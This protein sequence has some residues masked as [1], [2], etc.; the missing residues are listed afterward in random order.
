M[1]RFSQKRIG[2]TLGDPKGIGPEVVQKALALP[3][4]QNQATFS[5]YGDP[6]FFSYDL[7]GP[8]S[9]KECGKISGQA[10][11]QAVADALSKKIDA[12]VTAPIC[13]THFHK[14]G[15]PYPGHTEFLAAL[16]KTKEV[17]MMMAGPKLRVVL[18]SI[19]IPLADVP[20]TL[21][22]ED[23]FHTLR[24][25][26]KALRE[27]FDIP[28]PRIAVAGLNPHAGE[29]GLFG[30][31]EKTI[32]QPVIEKARAGEGWSISDPLPADTLFY[33]HAHGEFDAVIALYHDQ[34]LA[35][36]KLLH[37]H[38]AVNI[39]LGLPIIRV[40]VDHGTAFEIA[41]K[42]QA[43]ATNMGCAIQMALKL[44]GENR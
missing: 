20:K 14:A 6:G 13:K 28:H 25:T 32:L 10:I 35:P 26:E 21:N 27:W 24:L 30:H 2:I 33:R 34:G 43:D 40:S 41:G 44:T 1:E 38:E 19:H 42:N 7:A 9:E 15:Y 12:I 23:F 18:N 36:L 8:L 16:T 22:Q 17:R 5:L 11:E 37:F 3:F 31:E 4:L 29:G 39:T